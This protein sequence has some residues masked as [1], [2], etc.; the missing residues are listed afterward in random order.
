MKMSLFSERLV[1]ARQRLNMTQ[2]KLAE[3]LGVTPT[4]L[5]YWEKGKREPD[6]VMIQK[7]SQALKIDPN[8]LIGLDSTKLNSGMSVSKYET[9]LLQKYRKLDK[10]GK[11]MVDMTVAE[12]LNRIETQPEPR[13]GIKFPVQYYS[14]SVSAGDGNYLDYTTSSIEYIDEEPPAGTDYMLKVQGD[15]MEPT[16]YEDDCVFVNKNEQPRIGEIGIFWY[17]GCVYIK[18]Y[19]REGLVSHNPKYAVIKAD[20]TIRCLGKVIGKL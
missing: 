7:L 20:E 15:S 19:G 3:L 6:V 10:H 11:K 2:R 18:E 14:Q 12:E 16:F 13:L 8:F 17:D 4:R 9:E 5:N 1:E